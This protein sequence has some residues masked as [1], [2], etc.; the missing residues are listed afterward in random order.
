MTSLLITK[1]WTVYHFEEKLNS[2][3]LLFSSYTHIS[4]SESISRE[5]LSKRKILAGDETRDGYEE[6]IGRHS[7]FRRITG[8][9]QN[10]SSLQISS[11]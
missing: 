2:T 3:K 6:G 9:C 10:S 4:Q 1:Y 7:R 8:F 5:A 11:S